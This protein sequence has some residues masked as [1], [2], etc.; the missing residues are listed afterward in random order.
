MVPLLKLRL[1][2]TVEYKTILYTPS[3][4]AAWGTVCYHHNNIYASV[5][6]M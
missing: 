2:Q 1:L 5:V 4:F 6:I 3:D